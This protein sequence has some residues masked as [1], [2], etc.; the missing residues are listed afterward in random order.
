METP[1]A[2]PNPDQNDSHPNSESPRPGLSRR[3]LLGAAGVGVG[4]AAV[5]GT[6]VAL[7]RPRRRGG[8]GGADGPAAPAQ[9]GPG[10]NRRGN[11]GGGGNVRGG[12][13]NG[14]VALDRFSRLF[15]ERP[16][17]RESDELTEA[18]IELGRPGG[19]MD[20]N[21]PLE[22][23]PVDL[24]LDPSLS[25]NNPDNPT[26]T[27][28]ITFVGQFL[29]HDITRD[30]G[31]QLGRRQGL[32]TSLN[33]RTARFDLDSVYGGGPNEMPE[34]YLDDDP[35]RFRVESG[36]LFE[37]IPRAVDGSAILGDNRNDENMIISGLHCAFLL[38]HNA[39]LDRVLATG[40][41]D[42]A[43]F[44]ETQ[45]IVRWHYQWMIL[46]EWLP[47][48]VG[49]AMVDDILS[50]G[51][52]IYNPDRARIPVEFQT[53]AYRM[54]HSMI[55]PSYRAN[56]AG[57]SGDPFFAFVFDPSTFGQDDPDSLAGGHRAP[58]RF[59]GWQ[60]FFDFGDGEVRNN[61]RVDTK[62]STPLFNL[63]LST[64]P[65]TRGEEIGP[66]SLASRNLLRHI[67]WSIPSGQRIANVMGEPQL[68]AGDLPELS[69]LGANL[70]ES[71][72][73]FYYI[74]K[75]AEVVA[76]GLHLGPV[77]GRIVAEVFIGLLQLDAEAYVNAE[78]GWTP[79]LPMANPDAGYRTTD[80]LTL[81][82]VDP[83]SR[84]Q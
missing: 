45:R 18:L 11:N 68:L 38:W 28:G 23:G 43:A 61:K 41:D 67:T 8:R 34:L 47:A 57:D 33:L 75:E 51:R 30:A 42:Q 13:D 2:N 35:I 29:D 10:N 52:R 60:T 70:D 78:P 53:S 65:V 54:G 81:A 16:F 80:F 77:G 3:R 58:R 49:Q 72:P 55:R 31:S 74:L 21:D 17:A 36:G 9:N 26:N 62:I 48:M 7:A 32:R 84:G 64:L 22:R 4:V 37:D 12:Q 20:A 5:S 73:L 44:A 19:L 24:I 79:S 14:D 76:D 6:G 69:D 25:I 39:V 59:I 40:L 71:T 1:T 82:G 46:N 83:D 63:P 15:D 27:A 50:N 56:L 66:T